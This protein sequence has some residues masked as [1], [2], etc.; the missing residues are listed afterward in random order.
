MK[1]KKIVVLGGAFNPPTIEHLNLM[2]RAINDLNAE[3]GIFVPAS[4]AVVRQKMEN[5]PNNE[6]VYS[7]IRRYQM[8][9]RLC[10]TRGNRPVMVDICEYG[11]NDTRIYDTLTNIQSRYPE[12]TIAYVIDRDTLQDVPT[13]YKSAEI[14]QQFRLAIATRNGRSEWAEIVKILNTTEAF[15]HIRSHFCPFPSME[16]V[17]EES[18]ILARELIRKRDWDHLADIVSN[19]VLNIIWNIEGR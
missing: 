18:A 6:I 11:K 16:G 14:L 12:H 9:S 7:Q 3:F 17:S 4:D 2:L 19:D 8:L 13:W 10:K 1:G 5:E 15:K